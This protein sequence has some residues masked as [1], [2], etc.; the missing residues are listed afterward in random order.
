[1]DPSLAVICE[2]GLLEIFGG[3][4]KSDTSLVMHLQ[5]NIYLWQEFGFVNTSTQGKAKHPDV[6]YKT[7]KLKSYLKQER[8]KQ[9]GAGFAALT[10]VII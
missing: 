1:M 4:A 6:K 5:F 2:G 8:I 7:K 10:Q 3:S 9:Q